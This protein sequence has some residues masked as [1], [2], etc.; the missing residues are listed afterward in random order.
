M[1]CSIPTYAGVA[2]AAL[3][4]ATLCPLKADDAAMTVIKTKVAALQQ[5]VQTDVNAAPGNDKVK[6]ALNK[7]RYIHYYLQFQNFPKVLEA[8]QLVV[9]NDPSD[10]VKKAVADLTSAIAATQGT[11]P[12]AAPPA[13]T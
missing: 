4:L 2:V 6:V 11:Q 13:G 5:A 8:A 7:M 1:K 3:L 12:K 9:T 10:P